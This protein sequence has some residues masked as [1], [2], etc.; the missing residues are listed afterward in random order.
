MLKRQSIWLI[1]SILIARTACLFK[2]NPLHPSREASNMAWESS[3][4]TNDELVENMRQGGLISNDVI[5][6]VHPLCLTLMSVTLL[7]PH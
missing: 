2:N 1:R 5:A 6:D 4:E 3:G 7:L